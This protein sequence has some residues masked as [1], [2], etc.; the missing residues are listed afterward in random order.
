MGERR[1]RPEGRLRVTQRRFGLGSTGRGDVGLESVQGADGAAA[2]ADNAPARGKADL[3]GRVGRV[4]LLAD[5][6]GVD[7]RR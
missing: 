4:E 7:G 3:A 2:G 5:A 6:L 1:M